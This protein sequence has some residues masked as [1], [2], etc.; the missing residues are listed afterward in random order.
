[1]PQDQPVV[2]VAYRYDHQ[3]SAQTVKTD[4]A[5]RAVFAGLD[6]TGATSYFAMTVL[7]RQAGSVH[8]R[9]TSGPIQMISDDGLR[10]MLSGEKR[11]ADKPAIDDLSSLAPQPPQPVAPGEIQVVIAG[12]P[13]DKVP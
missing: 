2:L 8:D 10:L 7:P 3:V 1:P 11:D 6:R 13:E 12:V 4:P 5:G 9:L